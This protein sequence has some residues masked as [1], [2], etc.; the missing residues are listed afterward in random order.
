MP[1]HILKRNEFEALSTELDT[2]PDFIEFL[3]KRKQLIEKGLLFFP[4]SILDFLAFYKTN[5]DKVDRI[6]KHNTTSFSKM[7]FGQIIKQ[8]RQKYSGQK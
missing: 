1:I 3:N 6:I 5:P 4:T 2:V 7:G 8:L